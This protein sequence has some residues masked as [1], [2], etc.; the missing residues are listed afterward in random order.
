MAR[1][2]RSRRGSIRTKGW[3]SFAT[4][5]PGNVYAALQEL[6]LPIKRVTAANEIEMPCPQHFVRVG[7][8]D[9]HISFSVH[10]EEGYF[11]CFSCGYRGPFVLL[12]KDALDVEWEDAVAWVRQRGGI[13]RVR[14]AL[15]MDIDELAVMPDDNDTTKIINE[16]KLAL[17]E[18]PPEEMLD[19]RGLSLES[20]RAYGVRWDPVRDLWIAPIREP[21]TGTLLGWQEKNA[22]YFRNRPYDVK[23]SLCVFGLDAWVDG[24]PGVLVESPLDTAYTHTHL[25]VNGLSGYGAAVSDAQLR[26]I[27]DYTDVLYVALDND[28]DGHLASERIRTEWGH[29]MRLK[30]WD[31]TKT[32]AKD[33]GEETPSELV[34]SY[35][36][37][38]S[39]IVARF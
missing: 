21:D 31:Y 23:K 37:A 32:D 17:F 24:R 28:R 27:H 11:N 10:A 18:D 25:P 19:D 15:G 26:I 22:R 36:H 1:R 38:Y 39:S 7:K 8:E 9:R 4:P 14:R 35:E 30:F 13:E 16:A 6:N 33:P 3:D 2:Q 12:V 34:Y 29:K 20:V 5:V